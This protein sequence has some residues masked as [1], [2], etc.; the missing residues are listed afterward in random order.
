MEYHTLDE[1]YYII[2]LL[3]YYLLNWRAIKEVANR[4]NNQGAICILVDIR[5]ALKTARLKHKD[6]RVKEAKAIEYYYLEENTQEE[7]AELLG[8]SQGAVSKLISAGISKLLEEIGGCSDGDR[9][10]T[11]VSKTG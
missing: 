6:L 9:Q 2:E 11:R 10:E 1:E 7:T 4:Q 3:E 8:V 5:Q